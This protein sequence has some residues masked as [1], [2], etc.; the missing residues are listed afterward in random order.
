MATDNYV[1]PKIRWVLAYTRS[2]ST[3]SVA[4]GVWGSTRDLGQHQ[5]IC[6]APA[7]FPMVFAVGEGSISFGAL[8]GP[9]RIYI[10]FN[11]ILLDSS[12]N[13]REVFVDS[14][15]ILKIYEDSS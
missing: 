4:P 5:G 14:S 8:A 10:L 7:V 9:F 6:G 11:Y 1:M 13:I 2:V 3:F 12:Y 15:Y